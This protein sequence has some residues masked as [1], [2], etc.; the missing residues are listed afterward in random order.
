MKLVEPSV[1]HSCRGR[2]RSNKEYNVVDDLIPVGFIQQLVEGA[3]IDLQPRVNAAPLRHIAPGTVKPMA[4]MH[5]EQFVSV[6]MQDQGRH[7]FK[8][9]RVGHKTFYYR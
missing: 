6:P 4:P 8:H 1:Q 9:L 3:I 5:R 7:P 2:L